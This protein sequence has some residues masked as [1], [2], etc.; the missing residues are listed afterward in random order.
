AVVG[1]YA[2]DVPC[3]LGDYVAPQPE[4]SALSIA[5]ALRTALP[6][7]T[8][9]VAE[10][11]GPDDL[12]ANDAPGQPG[13]GQAALADSD[14]VIVVVGGTSRQRDRR[15]GGGPRGHLPPRGAGRPR[16]RR[17]RGH[18]RPRAGDRGRGRRPTARA[19]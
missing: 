15:G 18:S 5:E 13:S 11:A 4:G 2:N 19:H 10:W 7:T 16:A 9:E 3:M 6:Q 8:V 17:P 1:P 12:L 14:A